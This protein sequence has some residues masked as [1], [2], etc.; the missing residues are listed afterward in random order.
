MKGLQFYVA[1]FQWRDFLNVTGGEAE[2][3]PRSD[4]ADSDSDFRI[5]KSLR[6]ILG[7]KWGQQMPYNM[8]NV[9][10]TKDRSS[11]QPRK[12]TTGP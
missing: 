11:D 3:P 12:A 5:T 4:S 2:F 8:Y 10:V 7:K 6:Q 9:F 1:V